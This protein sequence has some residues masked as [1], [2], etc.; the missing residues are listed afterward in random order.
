MFSPSTIALIFDLP[1]VLDLL[2]QEKHN[3]LH[4]PDE[5]YAMH[6]AAK[7]NSYQAIERLWVQG[8]GVKG[9]DDSGCAPL[10]Y[11]TSK[12]VAQW[13]L[14]KGA[15]VNAEGGEYGNALQAAAVGGK[16]SLVQVLLDRGAN[17]NPK[18]GEYGSALQAAAFGGKERIVH[19]LLDRGAHV[20]AYSENALH[21]AVVY[22]RE[23]IK[24]LL[25]DRGAREV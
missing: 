1:R 2:E 24:I 15:D 17:V 14:D 4:Y 5:I 12:E 21:A 22:Q 20:N 9:L 10:Y 23:N 11:V 16:E 19:L 13:L 7:H 25:F 3:Q 6:F 8:I 18:S